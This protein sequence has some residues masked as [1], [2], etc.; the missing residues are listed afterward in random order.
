MINCHI[1]VPLMLWTIKF[2]ST[3]CQ[4]KGKLNVLKGR[5]GKIV[6]AEHQAWDWHFFFSL[7]LLLSNCNKFLGSFFAYFIYTQLRKGI[8]SSNVS[9]WCLKKWGCKY[10][11][12][13]TWSCSRSTG[14]SVSP[15]TCLKYGYIL[16]HTSTEVREKP[17]EG[18]HG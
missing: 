11:S 14:N 13:S 7:A 18:G 12:V 16:E 10:C 1:L 2:V 9:V 17:A 4:L 15:Q 6:W 3:K 5:N 8:V